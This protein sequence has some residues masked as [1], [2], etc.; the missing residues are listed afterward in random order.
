MNFDVVIPIRDGQ[1]HIIECLESLIAQE[2]LARIV[3]IDDGSTDQSAVLINN[4]MKRGKSV[5]L[6]ST[7]PRGLS[8]ARNFGVS[9]STSE[10]V[11]FLDSDDF[12]KPEKMRFHRQHIAAHKGCTFSFSHAVEIDS[13][14]G[15]LCFQGDNFGVTG[16]VSNILL[17]E[18]RVWGSASSAVV[19]RDAFNSIG[20]F[21]ESLEYGE[22]WDLWIR[23]ASIQHPCEIREPLTVIRNHGKSMQR[24]PR[25]GEKRFL[26]SKIYCTEWERNPYIFDDLRFSQRA[27]EMLW[28]DFRKN[29]GVGMFLKGDFTK[30]ISRNFHDVY[31]KLKS[32]RHNNF[33]LTLLVRRIKNRF[34]LR[35]GRGNY[36]G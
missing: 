21:D 13:G 18:F 10:Y 12:W 24:I 14:S 7:A 5:E 15:K 29:W 25:T 32:P 27:S 2:G 20:G 1:D 11:A 36:N 17:Q 8:A 3:V 26:S 31:L 33:I 22:D 19:N 6:Y 28:G 9:L 23:L 34:A 16:S 35:V 4:F 30:Y